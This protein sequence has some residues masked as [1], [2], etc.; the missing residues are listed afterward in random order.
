MALLEI[1]LNA[2]DQTGPAFQSARSG[3][4]TV[5]ATAGQTS[6]NL[7][8]LS[9]ASATTAARISTLTDRIRLGEQNLR[10]LDSVL[11]STAA[12]HAADSVQVQR[13]QLAYDRQTA[14]LNQNRLALARLER[15]QTTATPAMTRLGGGIGGITTALGSLGVAF[16]GTQ[17]A[18]FGIDAIGAANSLEKTEATLRALAGTQER[19]DEVV[20]LSVDA[21]NL[22]GG[23]LQEQ[24]EN[25][26]GL[27]PLSR[28]ANVALGD[29]DQTVRK[30]AIL[31]PNSAQGGG[32][33]IAI[34]EF[35]T[36]SDATGALSLQHRFELDKKALQELIKTYPD[37]TDRLRA[38]NEMLA[39]QGI[40]TE[41]LT[42]ASNTNAA[43]YDRLGAAVDRFK[44]KI[45]SLL[46]EALVPYAESLTGVLKILSG[47]FSGGLE[48]MYMGGNLALG[49]TPEQSRARMRSLP[50]GFGGATATA[51]VAPTARGTGG[52]GPTSMPTTVINQTINVQGSVL[53]E[54]ELKGIA[55]QG[56]LEYQSRN[57]GTGIRP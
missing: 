53:A 10:I 14:S 9:A 7:A 28:T 39:K 47:D 57:G 16:G 5:A 38:L 51:M 26:R 27:I 6:G 17:I 20:R 2:R 35:L 8:T 32:A 21:Q 3:L 12:R 24:E 23:T 40:T 54:Q 31:D 19:Y 56:L 37:A 50:F 36:A 30:L 55:H 15:E 11:R 13:A 29:L 48:N 49:Y 34:R 4:G 45:G 42:A 1:L 25:F 43:V 52:N 18:R 46:S 44:V 41:T 33:A 22:Y